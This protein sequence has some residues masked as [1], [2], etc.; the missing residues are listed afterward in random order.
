[1]PVALFAVMLWLQ[2]QRPEAED[3][4]A[5]DAATDLSVALAS[6]VSTACTHGNHQNLAALYIEFASHV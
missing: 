2:S 4:A 1:M 6:D 3:E 5:L